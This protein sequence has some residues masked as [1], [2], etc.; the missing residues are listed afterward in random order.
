MTRATTT[1]PRCD[2][3]APA[4]AIDKTV[5]AGHDGGVRRVPA[6]ESVAGENGDAVTYCFAVTNTGDDTVST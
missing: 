6:S 3:V 2:E 1:P 4:I 5:Y